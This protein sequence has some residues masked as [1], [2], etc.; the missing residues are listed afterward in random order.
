MLSGGTQRAAKTMGAQAKI[1]TVR[2]PEAS[3]KTTLATQRPMPGQTA[4]SV[5]WLPEALALRLE[6]LVARE[7]P[8]EA[9]K[10]GVGDH[11]VRRPHAPAPH[12]PAAL[13]ELEGLQH[14]EPR[15]LAQAVEESLDL[16]H[17][18]AVGE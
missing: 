2:V 8:G 11:P 7:A 1:A 15:E 12:R 9:Q 17:V 18:R 4:R 5:G 16:A 10:P 3:S 14:P 13:Q 6:E